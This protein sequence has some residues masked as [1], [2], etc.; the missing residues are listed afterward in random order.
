MKRQIKALLSAIAPGPLASIQ[1][2]RARRL[3]CRLQHEWGLTDL[4]NRFTAQFGSAVLHGPFKGTELGSTAT[5]SNRVSKMLGCYEAALNP[6]WEEVRSIPFDNIIDVGCADGYFALGFARCWK[7]TT[8]HAFDLDPLARRVVTE[9]GAV[10]QVSSRLR[11][12]GACSH[13]ALNQCLRGSTLVLSD[14]EGFESVLLDPLK[15]PALAHAHLVVELH[16]NESPRVH[17]QMRERFESTHAVA[18]VLPIS[19]EAGS[20]RELATFS[21]DEGQRMVA[22]HRAVGNDWYVMRPR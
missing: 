8:V 15:V 7:T 2:I 12:K 11:V 21:A 17:A 14:C 19:P 1:A 22:E 16:E 3:T 4:T 10:N 5:W 6:Y 18:H 9:L 20:F 13:L